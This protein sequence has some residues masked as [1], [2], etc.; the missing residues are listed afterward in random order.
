MNAL[1]KGHVGTIS[2]W[3]KWDVGDVFVSSDDIG[4]IGWVVKCCYAY[5][6]WVTELVQQSMHA[7]S[8][9]HIVDHQI[10]LEIVRIVLDEFQTF[11]FQDTCSVQITKSSYQIQLCQS[12]NFTSALR[13][14]EFVIERD[15]GLEHVFIG[16]FKKVDIVWS[17]V[18]FRVGLLELNIVDVLWSILLNICWNDGNIVTFARQF[19][20]NGSIPE[21]EQYIL[22]A[23][24]F[25]LNRTPYQIWWLGL[26][27]PNRQRMLA[28]K[29]TLVSNITV[30]TTLATFA[31]LCT[32]SEE[33]LHAGHIA[34]HQSSN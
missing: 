7:S 10:E 3:V 30:N 2:Q 9:G 27:T 17:A 5:Q 19:M 4:H 20:C 29:V 32:D 26:A 25:N 21:V 14:Y 16:H 6:R 12:K 8:T 31:I 33:A 23:N 11:R 34:W 15:N 13:D 22:F 28:P 1:H 18:Q 24:P